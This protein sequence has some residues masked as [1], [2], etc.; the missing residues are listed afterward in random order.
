MKTRTFILKSAEA[1]IECP[2]DQRAETTEIPSKTDKHLKD[3]QIDFQVPNLY[4][5]AYNMAK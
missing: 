1:K 4:S 3:P 2:S 5:L